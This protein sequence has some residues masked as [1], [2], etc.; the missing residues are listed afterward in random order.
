MVQQCVQV[1]RTIVMRNRVDQNDF[2]RSDV[3]AKSTAQN[4]R[5]PYAPTKTLKLNL[6]WPCRTSL[7]LTLRLLRLKFLG[8]RKVYQISI[9]QP[10]HSAPTTSPV[11]RQFFWRC[12]ERHC[13]PLRR[14][15][16]LTDS[17]HA[18]QS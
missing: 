8:L 7:F 5:I 6:A 9:S 16:A 18:T 4:M 1:G 3:C 15:A 2:H 13:N 11:P 17:K 12:P 14:R 10:S